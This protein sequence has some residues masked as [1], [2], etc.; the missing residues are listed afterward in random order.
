MF[1]HRAYILIF[2]YKQ[3]LSQE[4][5]K[6]IEEKIQETY[7]QEEGRSRFSSQEE[8]HHQHPISVLFIVNTKGGLLAKRL[9]EEELKLGQVTGYRVRAA[10][11][12]EMA[13]S[14]LLPST[15]PWD[16][17]DCR[18]MDCVICSQ[19]DD[20]LQDCIQRNLVYENMPGLSGWKK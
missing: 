6:S 8:D 12:A 19:D 16:S 10:E 18:R 15:N 17:E 13:L 5:G 11:T 3:N 9:Q 14:R 7:E 2:N 1:L 20:K 4:E